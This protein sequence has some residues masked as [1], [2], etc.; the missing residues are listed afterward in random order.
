MMF[1]LLAIWIILMR[2][3]IY[4]LSVKNK[5]KIYTIAIFIPIFLLLAFKG[6]NVGTDTP[7]YVDMYKAFNGNFESTLK[8]YKIETGFGV[9]L[10]F[11]NKISSNPQLLFIVEG[12]IVSFFYGAFF[13][14]K[15]SNLLLAI[16]AYLAFGLFAFQLTGIRQSIAMALCIL[17]FKC[18]EEKR[19]FKFL[20]II[21]V[22]SLFH[23]SA[24]FFIPAYFVGNIKCS[25][26]SRNLI[27]VIGLLVGLNLDRFL[28]LMGNISERYTAYGIESTGNGWIFFLIVLLI[29][30]FMEFF[31]DKIIMKNQRLSIYFNINYIS[32]ILWGMRL[33][34]RTAERVSFFYMPATIILLSML[35]YCFKN[36]VDK[37][38]VVIITSLLLIILYL[39]RTRTL[40]YI[41]I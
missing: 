10:Y 37:R 7:V 19:I 36:K 17:S 41:F 30:I 28:N 31:K 8:I 3:V 33:I 12:I 15:A 18:I 21:I 26:K 25:S 1:L 2:L 9:L 40:N 14:K 16:L 24:L 35:P 5:R 32:C 27:L 39:Y 38:F 29:T 23:T 11:L 4:S 34:T 13:Y 6:L 22:S 20:G